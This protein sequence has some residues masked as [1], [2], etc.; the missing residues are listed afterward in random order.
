LAGELAEMER[1]SMQKLADAF[2]TALRSDL[3]GADDFR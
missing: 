1:E 2:A 3:I